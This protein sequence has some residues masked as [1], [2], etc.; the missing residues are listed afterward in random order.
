[1][2]EEIWSSFTEPDR[3]LFIIEIIT[4]G[5]ASILSTYFLLHIYVFERKKYESMT[6]IYLS[7]LVMNMIFWMTIKV[8]FGLVSL[9]LT[10]HVQ[11]VSIIII[12]KFAAMAEQVFSFMIALELNLKTYFYRGQKVIESHFLTVTIPIIFA[13]GVLASI[14]NALDY[15]EPTSCQ[16]QP[17]PTFVFINS[18]VFLT[19]FCVNMLL[20]IIFFIKSRILFSKKRNSDVIIPKK[21]EIVLY[22]LVS[23]TIGVL[24]FPIYIIYF[25]NAN[26]LLRIV[27]STL[28]NISS[29]LVP[30]IFGWNFEL[31]A[32][33]KIWINKCRNKKKEIR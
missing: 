14:M 1:M 23:I 26:T 7:K 29:I 16:N 32:D 17:Y 30:I 20:F 11:C 18:V 10:V 4:A 9:L 5:I 19:I 27:F 31:F 24:R 13:L 12:V 15:Y 3:T 22:I 8:S 6:K 28:N 33:Y 25:Q 21:Q 2:V